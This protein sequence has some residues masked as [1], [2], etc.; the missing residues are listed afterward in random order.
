MFCRAKLSK[1]TMLSIKGSLLIFNWIF[2][3]F[4]QQQ[5]RECWK[6][7]RSEKYVPLLLVLEESFEHADTKLEWK[8]LSKIVAIVFQ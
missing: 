8:L 5:R 6:K 4:L 1:E 2:S 3:L 7:K